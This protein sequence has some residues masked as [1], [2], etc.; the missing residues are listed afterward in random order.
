MHRRFVINRWP[1]TDDELYFF[2]RGVWGI[3]IPRHKVCLHHCAPFDAFADAYFARSSIAVWKACVPTDTLIETRNGPVSMGDIE[4]GAEVYGWG[5]WGVVVDK[6]IVGEDKVLGLWSRQGEVRT[7]ADHRIRIMRKEIDPNGGRGNPVRWVDQ[8]VTA[9]EVTTSDY[10]LQAFDYAHGESVPD[11]EVLGFIVGDGFI[12]THKVGFAHHADAGYMDHYRKVILE[13]WGKELKYQP[14]T[15][16]SWLWST[17]AALHY[18]SYGVGTGALNKQVP[19]AVM[20]ADK[21]SRLAFLRGYLDADGT[22]RRDGEVVWYSASRALL[23]QVRSLGLSC[24]LLMGLVRRQKMAG[25][26]VVG[27]RTVQRGDMYSVAAYAGAAEVVGTNDPSYTW[28][29]PL[30]RIR[31]VRDRWRGPDWSPRGYRA[32]KVS[33]IVDHG[34]QTVWDMEVEGTESFCADTFVVHN[35][36][37]LGGKTQMLGVLALTEA[38]T[39]A[40]QVSVLGGSGQQSLRVHEAS[41]EAWKSPH[42]PRYLLTQPPTRYMTNFTTSAWIETLMASQR[43]VRGGHPQRLRLDE[44]DEMEEDILQASLGQPMKGRRGMQKGVQTHTVMS[45]THQHPDGTMSK[46]LA[47]AKEK[48]WPRWEWCFRETSNPIDGWLSQDEIERTRETIPQV[49]WETEYELQEPSFEGRAIDTMAVERMFDPKLGEIEQ[50]LWVS[51]QPQQTSVLYV[52]GV[53]WAKEQDLTVAVTFDVH[54]DVWYCVEW[55]CMNRLPWPIQVGRVEK[56]FERWGGFF[57]HDATGIGNVISDYF[58]PVLKG[59]SRNRWADIVMGGTNRAAIFSEYI[60]AIESDKIRM[61]RIARPYREHRYV[62][63]KDLFG[64]GHPPDSVVA[65]AVAWFMRER[66]GKSVPP[67]PHGM[68]RP[69]PWEIE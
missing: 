11:A 22:I 31:H 64:S 57:A 66:L 30:R 21:N 62:T 52:T 15:R 39:M 6:W 63:M 12:S 65:G 16:V 35:S 1:V 29:S 40:A 25:T 50:D 55:R 7:T 42:A 5:G 44:I 61:P 9:G 3:T 32:C 41:Q 34:V 28:E 23:A 67:A 20:H 60:A 49:M 51:Q 38:T 27:G 13:R 59:R 24:G 4:S 26:C 56:Q 37:G 53:D 68:D 19:D 58:S 36:R 48:G 8:W 45:S 33:R 43:S 54:Q 2:T 46:Q 69:N 18:A 47:L 14:S 10:L 17:E